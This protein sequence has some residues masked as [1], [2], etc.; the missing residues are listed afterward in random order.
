MIEV[1]TYGE[2][3][4]E[5]ASI[6]ATISQYLPDTNKTNADTVMV[7]TGAGTVETGDKKEPKVDV[8]E[9]KKK[10]MKSYQKPY[11]L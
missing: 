4:R 1:G 10:Q 3:F 11:G 2:R 5:D 6:L 9:K 7:T 8:T